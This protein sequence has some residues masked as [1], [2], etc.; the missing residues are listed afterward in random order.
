MTRRW[1]P[2][3]AGSSL[4]VSEDDNGELTW[5][6]DL[7]GV[8]VLT[9]FPLSSRIVILL[10]YPCDEL[11]SRTFE[12][13]LCY[14]ADGSFFW[15]GQLPDTHDSYVHMEVRDGVIYGTTWSGFRVSLDPQTGRVTNK[16]FVK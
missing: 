14:E 13:I 10:A 8:P 12:N 11:I 5:S 7:D 2:H 16:E 4:V 15:R 1:T 3:D 6:G 9:V